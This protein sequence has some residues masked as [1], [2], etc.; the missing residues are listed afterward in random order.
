MRR[1]IIAIPCMSVP[2]QWYGSTSGN[3]VSYLR[4]VEAA[5]GIPSLVHLSEDQ[6]VLRAHYERCD[7]VLFAGGDDVDP[8]RYGEARH[9]LLGET[10][11][12]QDA[13][14]LALAAWA[15]AD[16]KPVLGVCRGLQLLN[17]AWGGTLFQDI[18]SQCPDTLNHRASELNQ[19]W[20]LLAHSIAIEPDSWLAGQL[21]ADTTEVNTLHHQAIKDLAPGFR[22]T[23][24]ARDGMIEAIE[25]TS[26]QF[27]AAVQ[28]HPEELWEHASPRWQRF[29]EG[30]VQRCADH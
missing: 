9:P 14:E 20:T 10:S 1:P 19:Q 16:A 30:F 24:R 25:R 6:E 8:A 29:F 7:G 5:G 11:P 2:A 27:V 18:P 22:V 15:R 13:V 28:C 21:D 23:A 4:A 26:D 17:V 12:L 3:Y